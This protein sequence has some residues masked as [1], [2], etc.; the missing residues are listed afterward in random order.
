SYAKNPKGSDDPA[1]AEILARCRTQT[2]SIT[3]EEMT[4]RMFLPMLVE[5]SRVLAE[6]IVREPS[7]LDMGLILGI[8]FPRFRGGL[9]RWA[10][11]Q[12]LPKVLEKLAK[13]EHVGA[14]FKPT[15][16]MRQLAAAGRV[17][18]VG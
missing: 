6:N 3:A 12:G 13:Y 5:A 18:Y 1:L 8:G 14:R 11:E 7:E 15:E 16:Q 17:F 10:D 2:R 4:E 9:L